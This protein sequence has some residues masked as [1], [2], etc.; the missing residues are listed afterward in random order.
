LEETYN[1]EGFTPGTDDYVF[2]DKII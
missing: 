2:L 1:L